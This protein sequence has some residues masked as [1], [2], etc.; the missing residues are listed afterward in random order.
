MSLNKLDHLRGKI[1]SSY[2]Q[3]MSTKELGDIALELLL[4]RNEVHHQLDEN[5]TLDQKQE[6]HKT[7]EELHELERVIVSLYMLRGMKTTDEPLPN[8]ADY[9]TR[10]YSVYRKPIKS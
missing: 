4:L 10:R 7:I 3:G 9:F 6:I 5:P 1:A 8:F 2:G